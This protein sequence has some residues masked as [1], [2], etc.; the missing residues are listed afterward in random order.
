MISREYFPSNFSRISQWRNFCLPRAP[1]GCFFDE[2]EENFIPF[3]RFPH[4]M[5]DV[6]WWVEEKFPSLMRKSWFA[7]LTFSTTTWNMERRWNNEGRIIIITSRYN[8]HFLWLRNQQRINRYYHH[9][10]TFIPHHVR[11]SFIHSFALELLLLSLTLPLCSW[12]SLMSK[13]NK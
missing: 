2:Y 6:I 1:W 4:Y 3:S 5:R 8:S 11:S 10:A 12:N 7:H 13:W 9:Q